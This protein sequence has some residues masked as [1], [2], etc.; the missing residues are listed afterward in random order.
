MNENDSD[1]EVGNRT[2]RDAAARRIA[3]VVVA[4]MLCMIFYSTG[5]H[6]G[7]ESMMTF[8]R[9]PGAAPA[10]VVDDV[11]PFTGPFAAAAAGGTA[12]ERAAASSQRLEVAP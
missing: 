8:P 2:L 10:G 11:D 7:V 12:A 6:R 5:F 3:R 9:S 4:A 1:H